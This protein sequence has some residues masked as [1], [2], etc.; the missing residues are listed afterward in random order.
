MTISELFSGPV[1]C[2]IVLVR[3]GPSSHVNPAWM[4]AREFREW[5]A[6]YEAA[7]IRE[8][9]VAPASLAALAVQADMIVA[10]D[11]LRTVETA[12][13]LANGREVITSPLLRELALQGPELRGVSLPFHSWAL[14]VGSRIL[15][16]KLR[17]Q[18]PAAADAARIASAE[19]WIGTLAP[20]HQCVPVVTHASIR[21]QLWR[22]LLQSGW[23]P[24][25]GRRTMA[26]WSA[27]ICAHDRNAESAAGA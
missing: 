13:M 2:R 8:G 10:S 23:R 5:R 14:A 27:W 25:P 4:N 9:E 24:E 17:N 21:R 26:P 15:W 6:A 3:H 22:R 12:R 16:L 19:Q 20:Q 1:E 18:Y 7:G 11:S